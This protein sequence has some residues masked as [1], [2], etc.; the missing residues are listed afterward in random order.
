MHSAVRIGAAA[1][2]AAGLAACD[3]TD[4]APFGRGG[5]GVQEDS[6]TVRRVRGLEPEAPP[7]TYEPGTVWPAPSAEPPRALMP[8]DPPPPPPRQRT[9]SP[10]AEAPLPPPEPVRATA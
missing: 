3:T 9:G 4:F 2:L 7:L 5:P 6:P 8:A 10:R 1:L